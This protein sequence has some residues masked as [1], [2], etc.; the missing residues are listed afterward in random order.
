MRD[1]LIKVTAD[2]VTEIRRDIEEIK[3]KLENTTHKLENTVT[4]EQINR[5]IMMVCVALIGAIIV[6]FF[7]QLVK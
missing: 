2:D 4:H 6:A 3:R 7:H 5:F 1:S